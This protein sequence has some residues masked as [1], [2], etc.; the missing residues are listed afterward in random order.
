M[1]QPDDHVW[2]ELSDLRAAGDE[3][4]QVALEMR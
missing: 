4:P 3:L 1:T 2:V